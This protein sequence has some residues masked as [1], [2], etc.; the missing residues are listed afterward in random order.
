MVSYS[1]GVVLYYFICYFIC[2]S[3]LKKYDFALVVL[4]LNLLFAT[5]TFYWIPSE[6]PQGTALFAVILSLVRNEDMNTI[7]SGKMGL[8]LIGLVVMAFYH[9]LLVFVMI[10]SIAYLATRKELFSDKKLLILIASFFFLIIFLKA[11]FFRTPYEQHSMSGLKNFVTQFP[12]YFTL[13]SN[14]K[15]L[16]DFFTKYYWIPVLFIATVVMYARNKDWKQLLFFICFFVGYLFLVNISYPSQETPAFYIENLYLPLSIFLALPF[17]FDILPVLEKKKMA[18]AVFAL[19]VLTGVVR[20]YSAHT[21]YTARL[22]YERKYLDKYDGVKVIAKAT[23][24]D[25]VMLQMLWGTPYEFLLLSESERHKTA[26]IIID[27]TPGYR[28]WAPLVKNAL[29]VNWDVYPY[30]KLNQKYFHFT[31]TVSGYTIIK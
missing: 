20:I 14:K 9:P 6:L 13:Y 11:I 30:S 16:A 24:T 18:A 31:D 10:Y 26:S 23:E 1:A 8:L 19:I 5:D 17:V 21:T 28:F 7:G 4:L 22:D 29:M 25:H 15:F 2:G 12:D 27:D 3:V